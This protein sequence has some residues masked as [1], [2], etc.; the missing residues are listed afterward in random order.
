[1]SPRSSAARD[2]ER[3]KTGP[4]RAEA[5]GHPGPWRQQA[6]PGCESTAG[7]HADRRARVLSCNDTGGP[8]FKADPHP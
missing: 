5:A 1:M 4:M 7:S 3:R 8:L 6:A 2:P